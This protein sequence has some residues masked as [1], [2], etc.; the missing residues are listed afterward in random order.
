MMEQLKDRT[1]SKKTWKKRF[2]YARLTRRV[3]EGRDGNMARWVLTDF[4]CF[5]SGCAWLNLSRYRKF[6]DIKINNLNGIC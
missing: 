3:D 1:Q 5:D 6:L 4:E 2:S